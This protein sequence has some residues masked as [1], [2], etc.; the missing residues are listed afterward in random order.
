MTRAFRR[1]LSR[2]SRLVRPPRRPPAEAKPQL[3]DSLDERPWEHPFLT[4]ENLAAFRSY[5]LA[6]RALALDQWQQRPRM[7]DVG[8]SINL[9]QSMYKWARML[10]SAGARTSVYLHEWDNRALSRPEWEDFDGAWP[11]CMD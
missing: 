10:A 2:I 5:S 7:L 1:V 8:F 11:D 6:V 4:P 9:A 3:F